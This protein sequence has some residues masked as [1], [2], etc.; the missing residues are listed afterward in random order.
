MRAYIYLFGIITGAALM[1]FW[2]KGCDQPDVRRGDTT[3]HEVVITEPLPD[4]VYK[5]HDSIIYRHVFKDPALV[6][7][8][9]QEK[10]SLIRFAPAFND[11]V[12]FARLD[13]INR[14]ICDSLMLYRT[15]SH[16]VGDSLITIEA[17]AGVLGYL[18][19]LRIFWKHNIPPLPPQRIGLYLGGGAIMQKG[20]FKG[21]EA[22][23]MLGKKNL[24]GV[25]FLNIDGESYWMG[26]GAIRIK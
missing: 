18:D 13:S 19:T 6:A 10:D 8:L 24:Y 17:G 11:S 25:S 23:L 4:T 22:S 5:V 16:T 21:L 26:R 1:L 7:R 9:L 20:G 12:V 2:Q 3:S 15:Y 14:D